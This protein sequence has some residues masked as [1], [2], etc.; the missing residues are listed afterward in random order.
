MKKTK[1]FPHTQKFSETFL[2]FTCS[3]HQGRK[4]VM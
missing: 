1:N 4:I 2:L 3:H